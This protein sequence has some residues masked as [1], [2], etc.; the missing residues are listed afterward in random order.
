MTTVYPHSGRCAWC[1]RE[2]DD[3]FWHAADQKFYCADVFWCEA[4]YMIQAEREAQE[5]HA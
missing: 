4:R 1:K 3:L 5:N 2:R